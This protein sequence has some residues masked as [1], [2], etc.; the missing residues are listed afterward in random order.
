M[1]AMLL[2]RTLRRALADR[3]RGGQYTFGYDCARIA[4][5]AHGARDSDPDGYRAGFVQRTPLADGL[6]TDA[7]GVTVDAT[8]RR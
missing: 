5:L 3:L 7:T 8:A 4:P 1:P 6:S 2:P